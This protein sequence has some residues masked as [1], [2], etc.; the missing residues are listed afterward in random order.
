MSWLDERADACG[1]VA[2]DGGE[3]PALAAMWTTS[4]HDTVSVGDEVALSLSGHPEARAVI[5]GEAEDGRPVVAC[6]HC[7]GPFLAVDDHNL[8]MLLKRGRSVRGQGL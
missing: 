7:G 4:F 1:A 5:V 8:S 6:S 2:F 3:R